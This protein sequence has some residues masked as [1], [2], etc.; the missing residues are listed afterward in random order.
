MNAEPV[1]LHYCGDRLLFFDLDFSERLEGGFRN[2]TVAVEDVD[3][4][5][6]LQAFVHLV[7][8]LLEVEVVEVLILHNL[9]ERG[10]AP[11]VPCCVVQ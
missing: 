2:I 6:C 11:G 7:L 4:V 1:P 5:K 8:Q 9:L 10:I 3:D